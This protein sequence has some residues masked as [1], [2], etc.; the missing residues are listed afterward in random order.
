MNHP[1]QRSRLFPWP[2]RW[3]VWLVI[4]SQ[5]GLPCLVQGASIPAPVPPVASSAPLA[6]KQ[7]PPAPRVVVNRKLPLMITNAPALPDAD[8]AADNQ[9]GRVHIF[10]EPLAPMGKTTARENRDLALA[11]GGYLRGNGGDDSALT[12]YL[13][14]HPHSPWRASL[15]TD[16]GITWLH[17][18]R[19]SK[20]LTA[21]QEAWQLSK[22]SSD[23][24]GKAVADRA[25]GELANLDASLGRQQELGS[26]LDEIQGRKINGAVSEK[27]V[28]ARESDWLMRNYPERAF[29]CGALALSL[30][31]ASLHPGTPVDTRNMGA[32][33]T[34]DGMSLASVCDLANQ[35][36]LNFQM[37]KRQPGS[38]MI[39]PAV[40]HWQVGHYAAIIKSVNGKFWVKDPATQS[41]I[42]M[43][44]TALDSE[45]SGYFL[46][47]AG[48]LPSG[49][50]SVSAEEGK[51][52][53]GK[54]QTGNSAPGGGSGP[55][56]PLPPPCPMAQY[57]IHPML[58]SLH[59]WDTPVGYTPPRGPDMHF[60]V[61]YNQRDAFQP[62]I[63]DYSNLGPKWTFYWIS[64]I[65]DDPNNP[66]ADVNN[67]LQN[68]TTETYS[69]FN[70]DIQSYSLQPDSQTILVLSSPS[71]YVRLAQDGSKQVYSFPDGSKSYPR[72][73]F[74]T[75]SVDALGNT[76]T[77]SYDAYH[78]LAAVTD[79][80]GQVTTL[81]YGSTNT[82]DPFFFEI[83]RVTDPFGR[84]ASFAYNNLGQLV[85]ITD[86]LGISSQF[87]YGYSDD[88]T[89]DFVASLTTPY[90]T[91]TFAEGSSGRNRW[92]QATDPLGQS[93][94]M[95][96]DDTV[97][98]ANVPDYGQSPPNTISGPA[99]DYLIY[100]NTYFWDKQAMQLYPGDYT[101]AT[102]YHWLHGAEDINQCSETL[103]SIK[104]PL[105]SRFW[106]TYP[107]QSENIF[108]GDTY[109]QG[110]NNSV[111]TVARV[112]D[113][114]TTQVSQYIYNSFG[115][116][117][118][119]IDP[120][121]RITTNTYADNQIDLL[122]VQQQGQTGL[123]TLESFT[124]STNHLPLTTVDAAGNTNY[125][126][127]NILY[128]LIYFTNALNETMSID[129][130]TNGYLV[131][132]VAGTA[133]GGPLST[134]SFTY[135]A[136]GR[137]R[138]AT[139]PDGHYTTITYDA[140]DRPT[141]IMF[142]DGTFQQIAYN[143][144]DPVLQ[145]DRNGN[146]KSMTYNG[147]RQLTDAYDN[148]GRHAHYDWCGC[149][150]LNDIIDPA[151]HMTAWVHDLEGRTTAKIYP[152]SSSLRYS[153]ETNG[154][155]L[156]SVTDAKGQATQYGY[157]PDNNIQQISYSNAGVPTPG[158]LF[159]YDTNYNRITAMTDG[160]G[161]TAYSYYPT[162][163]GQPGAG[164]VCSV[165]NNFIG[166]SG[167]ITYGYD[168]LGRVIEKSVNG[169]TERVAMDA[170]HRVTS[171]ENTLGWFTNT[172]IGNSTFLST[173]FYPN[174]QY[175]VFG[176]NNFVDGSRLS[177][178]W[179][180]GPGDVTISKFDYG[181]DPVGNVTNW[182]VQADSSAPEA[183]SM[184]YDA[185]DQLSSVTIHSNSLDG[186]V[187]RQYG[188]GYDLSGN[189]VSS[190]V[191][192]LS[193]LALVT[194]QYN[195]LNE[196]TSSVCGG[197][198][199][200]FSGVLDR[201]GIVTVAGTGASMDR[202]K[203]NF[204]GFPVVANGT[205]IV[206]IVSIGYGSQSRTNI[207]QVIVTNATGVKSPV[208]DPD[209]NM[210]DDGRGTTYE[211][212]AANRITA[213]NGLT[214]LR[215]EYS[216]DG[217]GRRLQEIDK[218]NG[219]A[220]STNRFI[221][222]GLVPREVRDGTGNVVLK[223]FFGQGEQICGT[224]YFFTRDHL[225]SIR[226]VVDGS[227]VIQSRYCYDPYGRQTKLLGGIDAD[228]GYAGYLSVASQPGGL[229][230]LF[231]IYR[232]DLGVWTSRDPLTERGGINLYSFVYNNP[233]SD[234]DLIGLDDSA[235]PWTVGWEWLTGT[236]P[237]AHNFGNG[238]YFTQLLQKHGHVQ[239]L[240]D[241][242]Q[243][244]LGSQCANCDQTPLKGN[245]NYGLGGLQGVPK[246]FKDYSTLL[247]GGLTG[248]LAVTYLGSYQLSYQTTGI[249]C[250]AGTAQVHFHAYNEST[251][252]SATHP[253][254]IGYTQ[255]WN[256]YIGGPLNNFFAS[257]PMS[258]TTQTFDW[259]ETLSFAPNKCCK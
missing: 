198:P 135:D 62:S 49:W 152:D 156:I 66:G 157:S 186:Q 193:G 92:L 81:D 204:T 38:K 70:S 241:S 114:G 69:G 230:T 31:R 42:L 155:R 80:L 83:T 136:L 40:V 41:E 231:R 149:G 34:S 84:F 86:I 195:N 17:E 43:S 219:V 22:N 183:L 254:V 72:K 166:A 178:I 148:L 23:S 144:L 140:D 228:F 258:K 145:R 211:Y 36:G 90:G 73:I 218:T 189:R 45:A 111:A 123:D 200:Q 222:V 146:W 221:W 89:M 170:L 209:G 190:S 181:Y 223:R 151:G 59:I 188:Y 239:E 93:E 107:G 65:T 137:V 29:R 33:A 116:L 138:V 121:G 238:D 161:T 19:Y 101:K 97:S 130:D 9:I 168:A 6:L 242:L 245:D 13:A 18:G 20:A 16:L 37:A 51:A 216:Y 118:E 46:V 10:A 60:R 108:G 27:L 79:T 237:D 102:I 174:G 12:D 50:S 214:A 172:Y 103:E 85:K 182:T 246:Y 55:P 191:G 26:L 167:V 126:A 247:T 255:W 87:S 128:Q 94:R 78:R 139:D 143:Y 234:T 105:E 212:D 229:L 171:V 39:L 28:R 119:S 215:T 224:N 233:L 249:D 2:L 206:S 158:V 8:S 14:S 30:V 115:N 142:P 61:D 208:Y 202:S 243:G 251:M 213:I 259:D 71:N 57:D 134:N 256:S 199:V 252:A 96:Y 220:Y 67:Y 153:Y 129:Y 176:Y 99:P 210:I 117:V 175:T 164:L 76:L 74:L 173:N 88:G 7:P 5:A 25:L 147:L 131:S 196:M 194:A 95:E 21:W 226:E 100:R 180:L 244:Q 4:A 53:W 112:M 169:D 52:I 232:P 250:K 44:Q 192:T 64:Y 91:T 1:R 109:Q 32:R 201:P 253:P 113:D 110:T 106:Y 205:N 47:P 75:Q 132:V 11:L 160:T 179:N 248:N 141:N 124:Y 54:G 82:D 58:V 15:L 162:I 187:L 203:T 177:R 68:G 56:P 127:Y 48:P 197:G 217:Y 165:S 236:G 77:Y 133:P 120:A 150:S 185:A 240:R 35:L 163:A 98:A 63:F 24:R 154:G 122:T 159:T 104:K 125:Y 184:R 225:G 3:V 227:G 257:G 207:Y 235:G